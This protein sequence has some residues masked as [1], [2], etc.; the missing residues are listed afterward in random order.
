MEQN[1]LINFAEVDGLAVRRRGNRFHI[2]Q[3]RPRSFAQVGGLLFLT[4]GI[5]GFF[6]LL[7]YHYSAT[8]SPWMLGVAGAISLIVFYVMV[9]AL[10][11]GLVVHISPRRIA[12]SQQPWPLV[13]KRAVRVS[14]VEAVYWKTDFRFAEV[15]PLF[16]KPCIEGYQVCV[17]LKNDREVLLVS[18]LPHSEQA[19]FL[20]RVIST[21]LCNEQ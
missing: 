5:F 14:Q 10:F 21:Y 9:R 1:I 8:T 17:R 13:S 15:G 11:F 18:G 19:R 3:T 12:V 16:A 4:G 2:K 7:N 20:V 6:L